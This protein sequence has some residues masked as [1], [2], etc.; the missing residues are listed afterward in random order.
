MHLYRV[1]IRIVFDGAV[2]VK[3]QDET[4]AENIVVSD[5]KATLGN[6]TDNGSLYI[7]DYEVDNHG[8]TQCRD[9]ESVEEVEE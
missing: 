8:F 3:A 9:D 7:V 5:M 1:P 2:L 4:E 6:V